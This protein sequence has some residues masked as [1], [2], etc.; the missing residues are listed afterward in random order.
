MESLTLDIDRR[1]IAA[2]PH[3]DQW[4][5]L[6]MMLPER[7]N[8]LASAIAQLDIDTH[9][10]QRSQFAAPQASDYREDRDDVAII[11]LAGT[12][13]KHAMSFGEATSTVLARQAIRSAVADKGIRQI[14]LAIES[15]GGTA[16]GTM[17]LA[18]EVASAAKMKNVHAHITDIGASAAYWV[19]AQASHVT[20]N[21]MALVGSIG[22]YQVV[23]D[24]SA[25]AEKRGV[26][27][28]LV[29]AGEFKGAGV[30]GTKI[31]AEQLAY[32][33]DLVD[34]RNDLFVRGVATGRGVS[35]KVARSWADG[36]AHV[37]AQ[38]QKL[39]LI[40]AVGSFE[41]SLIRLQKGTVSMTATKSE[42]RLKCPGADDK[43]IDQCVADEMSIGDCQ[44]LYI[45]ALQQKNA[46]LQAAKMPATATNLSGAEPLIDTKASGK[47]A[48]G[49]TPAESY[50]LAV[51]EAEAKGMS[52]PAAISYVNRHDPELRQ[53][54]VAEANGR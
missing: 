35:E 42:I 52:R 32:M 38:A 37:A 24:L 12:L 19:A 47:R 29:K 4:A 11:H 16:A 45:H 20:A 33:Q 31:T 15:P 17:E 26:K 50:W 49:T 30:Q 23:T 39:G 7:L 41:D 28:H 40:D 51:H 18:A 43:F 27:V 6:W 9:V 48:A 3:I 44:T 21:P 2:V 1:A 13:Q 10:Q 46:E 36:K 22:T 54:L 53:A 34:S 8:F 14:M 5:G 25:L